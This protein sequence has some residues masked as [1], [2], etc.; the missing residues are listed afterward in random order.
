MTGFQALEN[1][2]AALL[3]L[4]PYRF[5]AAYIDDWREETSTARG[6]VAFGDHPLPAPVHTNCRPIRLEP[7]DRRRLEL[8]AALTTAGIA[9]LP[10]DLDAIEALCTLDDTTHIAL[11]R[12]LSGIGNV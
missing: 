12:W 2:P 9:P 6:T 4:D 1:T 11:R 8:H 10:G 7:A 5:P 3:D